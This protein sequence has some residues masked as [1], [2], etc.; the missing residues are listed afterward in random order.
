MYKTFKRLQLPILRRVKVLILLFCSTGIGTLPFMIY[1]LFYFI[2][3]EHR[4]NVAILWFGIAE[5]A[6]DIVFLCFSHTFKAGSWLLN[7]LKERLRKSY[8]GAS[9]RSCELFSTANASRPS[10]V[11]DYAYQSTDRI[12]FERQLD[13]RLTQVN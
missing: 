13:E 6:L 10:E 3:K 9:E 4:L 1:R 7:R 12:V 8:D 2:Q 5:G 11:S